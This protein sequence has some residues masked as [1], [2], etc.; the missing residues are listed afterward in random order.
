MKDAPQPQTTGYGLPC[1]K[2]HRYFPA[3]LPECPICKSKERVAPVAGPADPARRKA[4]AFATPPVATLTQ[5]QEELLK[6]FAAPALVS[7]VEREPS[8]V[9]ASLNATAAEPRG[10]E[11]NHQAYLPEQGPKP[12]MPVASGPSNHVPAAS[13]QQ[14][15]EEL[16][17]DFESAGLSPHAQMQTPSVPENQAQPQLN[18]EPSTEPVTLEQQREDLAKDLNLPVFVIAGETEESATP[19]S[20]ISLTDEDLPSSESSVVPKPGAT[21]EAEPAFRN[22]ELVSPDLVFK[23]PQP[24]IQPAMSAPTADTEAPKKQPENVVAPASGLRK[25]EAARPKPPLVYPDLQ[26]RTRKRQ[27]DILTIVLGVIVLGFAVFLSVLIGLH[28]GGYQVGARRSVDTDADSSSPEVSDANATKPADSQETPSSNSI[29]ISR[30]STAKDDDAAESQGSSSP[31]D[32]AQPPAPAAAPAQQAGQVKHFSSP[33]LAR[34]VE[35]SP[36]VAEDNLMDRVEPDYPDAA[37]ER[38]VQ[39]AVILDLFIGKDGSVKDVHLIS[40]PPPLVDSAM[41]AVR[42]WKFKPYRVNGALAETQ[43]RVTLG[44]TVSH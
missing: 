21:M 24:P 31:N 22:A 1:A 9:E 36:D 32:N 43:T 41:T 42:Q 17:R 19:A 16:V 25:A 3:D 30:S 14:W 2:C 10:T 40:G 33:A 23:E 28:L 8:L 26:R 20:T 11:S 6:Q 27:F 29:A 4:Q 7:E 15:R 38:G 39:G 35:L 44:F 37:R 12:P 34:P 13:L 5:E 18:D